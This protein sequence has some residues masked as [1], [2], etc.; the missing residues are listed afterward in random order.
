MRWHDSLRAAISVRTC[1]N[2]TV[3]ASEEPTAPSK[4]KVVAVE[5]G[6]AS[7]PAV[8]FVSHD[9]TIV[10]ESCTPTGRRHRPDQCRRYVE[11]A[12]PAH[13]PNYACASNGQS[14]VAA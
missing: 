14:P 10:K 8:R 7:Y 12:K 4:H 2:S 6:V 5:G 13:Q 11:Q 3:A 1:S 9:F